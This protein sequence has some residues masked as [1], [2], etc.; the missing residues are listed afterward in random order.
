MPKY[1]AELPQLGERVFL[2][3]GG[4]ETDLIFHYGMD[5]PLF[6]S[7]ALLDDEDGRAALRRYFEGYIDIA[8][9][10]GVGLVLETP[11]WRASADWGD[12]LGYSADALAAANGAAVDLLTALRGEH[13]TPETPIIISGNIGPRGDGYAPDTL[14]SPDEAQAYH[15]AQIETFADTEADLVTALTMT[16]TGEAIGVVRAAI[17]HGMPCGISFTVETDGVLPSGESL[18][19]AIRVVDD[20]T[21][22]APSFYMVNCAHPTHLDAVLRAGDGQFSRVRGL[23][24]NA[25]T[26]SHDELD[27]AE[28]LDEGD[29]DDLAARYVQLRADM[30]QLTLLGGCCGTDAHH[31]DAIARACIA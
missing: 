27:A 7:F 1:R 18:A 6:A 13:E 15:S 30:P 22:T 19:D 14:Q 24:A 21:G 31:I 10:S 11:T 23:R 4:L 17:E 9:R 28:E 8:R 20:A 26:L 12:Q 3:D 16:H 29:A 2:T 5:L 25:S